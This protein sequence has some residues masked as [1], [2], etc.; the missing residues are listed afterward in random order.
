M[1]ILIRDMNA[2][3]VLR[4]SQVHAE[5]FPRQTLSDQW[6][7]C[8]FN[9]FPRIRFF[10]AEIDKEI[11]G[12][13]QWTEKSG[14]RQEVVLELEQIG[15]LPSYQSQGIGTALISQSLPLLQNELG[16]RQASIK[17]IMVSTRADNNAQKLYSKTLNALPEVI[18]SNLFSADEVLMIS[19]NFSFDW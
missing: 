7:T 16:K 12:Y 14:F 1:N 2:E 15:V 5:A 18:I 10:I 9:A 19:R 4:V 17:H 6:I 3:D 11:M 8:N 13:I